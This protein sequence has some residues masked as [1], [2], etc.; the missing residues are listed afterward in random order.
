MNRRLFIHLFLGIFLF[1]GCYYSKIGV[2]T[3]ED[4]KTMEH[5]YRSVRANK[6]YLRIVKS[7]DSRRKFTYE[8]RME[9]RRQAAI[10]ETEARR[11][12]DH[13]ETL[14]KMHPD[15][16]DRYRDEYLRALELTVRN[17][18]FP[19]YDTALASDNLYN[20]YTQWYED[21]LSEI[22]IPK[23]TK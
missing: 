13:P 20:S 12:L 6:E 22:K 21:H 19:D 4:R 15:L 11:V 17:F 8:E 23:E 2:W 1:S 5:F 18:D 9:L 14:N 7:G 10:A 3:P 16:H